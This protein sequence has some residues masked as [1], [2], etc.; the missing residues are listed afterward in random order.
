V[1]EINSSVSKDT[2]AQ[3]LVE[4]HNGTNKWQGPWRVGYFDLLAVSYAYRVMGGSEGVHEL[5]LT[6]LDYFQS[7]LELNKE[8]KVCI[9]YEYLGK[10]RELAQ[11]YFNVQS[12]GINKERMCVSGIKF[13]PQS[14]HESENSVSS[15]LFDCIPLHFVSVQNQNSS[16]AVVSGVEKGMSDFLMLLKNKLGLSPSILSFGPTWRQKRGVFN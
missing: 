16:E 15:L 2:F 5:S 13:D 1:T 14:D 7:W 9:A 12:F 4:P 6:H 3:H 10:Q 8:W 11:K